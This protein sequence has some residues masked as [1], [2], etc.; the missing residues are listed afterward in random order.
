MSTKN[1]RFEELNQI[2]EGVDAGQRAVI[3][4]L[5]HEVVFMESEMLK[6]RTLPQIRIHPK[7]PTRQQVTAAGKR[8][9]ELMQTYTNAIKTLLSVLRNNGSEDDGGLLSEML[10]EFKQ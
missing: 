4:P 2:F 8:Y 7:D 10:K 6:L 3:V 1:E 9:R 5:L